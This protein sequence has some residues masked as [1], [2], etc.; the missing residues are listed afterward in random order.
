MLLNFDLHFKWRMEPS[1]KLAVRAYNNR[2][3][4]KIIS[5]KPYP[6]PKSALIFIGRSF[7]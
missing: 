1:Q 4:L 3:I 2:K 5:S 7:C 6:K